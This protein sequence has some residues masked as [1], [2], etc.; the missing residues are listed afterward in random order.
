MTDNPPRREPTIGVA[1]VAKTHT[2]GFER[3]ARLAREQADRVFGLVDADM[4]LSEARNHAADALETDVY[5][6]I[7]ADAYPTPG[8]ADA[9]RAGYRDGA[10][11][12]G[13]PA[14]P[15]YDRHARPD[16]IPDGWEWL[17]GAGPF[18]DTVR[19][20]RNTY[21]TNFSMR[22]AVFDDLGGFDES[23]GLGAPTPHGEETDLARRLREQYGRRMQYRPHAAVY[24]TVDAAQTTRPA[25]LRRAYAQGYT[26]AKIGSGDAERQFVAEQLRAPTPW[27]L[28][29]TTAAG[30]G[31]IRGWADD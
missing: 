20:V 16:R 11:A 18:H 4:A 30:V 5:A 3:C 7:D 25:L 22:A 29:L 19:M 6:F 17:V 23:L 28:A 15:V 2:P 1:I 27:R 21:G 9:L 10:L 13:G 26:K 12:V 8:W 14:R 31:A 24:H